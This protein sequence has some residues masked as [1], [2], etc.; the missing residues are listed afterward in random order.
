MGLR[1]FIVL[2]ISFSK[3]V[4]KRLIYFVEMFLKI[5]LKLID[6][7]GNRFRFTERLS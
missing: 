7:L 5:I 6:F 2:L 3:K 4:G 1:A